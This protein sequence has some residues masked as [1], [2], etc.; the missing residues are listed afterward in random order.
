MVKYDDS[1]NTTQDQSSQIDNRPGKRNGSGDA[2][3]GAMEILVVFVHVPF[4]SI[5][6]AHGLAKGPFLL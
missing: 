3:H 1:A 6:C 4:S 2:V 5:S